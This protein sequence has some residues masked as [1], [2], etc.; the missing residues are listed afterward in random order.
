MVILFLVFWGT[1]IL[2][3]IVAVPLYIPTNSVG[4]FPFLPHP[5][6]HLLFI[7]FSMM[8]PGFLKASGGKVWSWVRLSH[9]WLGDFHSFPLF[10]VQQPHLQLQLC[11]H[12]L[13]PS[14]SASSER[15]PPTLSGWGRSSC[16][17]VCSGKRVSEPNASLYR[18]LSI[19]PL[20]SPTCTPS[21]EV[22]DSSNSW[23]FWGS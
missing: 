10:P 11:V 15:K 7:D 22:S 17:A 21:S 3:S 20:F 12:L 6:Q 23:V 2:F 16:M 18:F 13:D 14:A 1:S 4:S 5:L 9:Q 8:L 19:P